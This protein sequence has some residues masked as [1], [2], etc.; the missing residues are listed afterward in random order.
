MINAIKKQLGII[1]N[2]L[3]TILV[4][5]LPTHE[6][7]RARGSQFMCQVMEYVK[8]E[9]GIYDN[10][11]DNSLK[12]LVFPSNRI[13]VQLLNS[14][15]DAWERFED[16]LSQKFENIEEFIKSIYNA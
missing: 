9:I 15:Y 7:N 3:K 1:P 10:P 6:M 14:P 8:K 5:E 4:I 16:T 11:E 13:N 12:V 2:A